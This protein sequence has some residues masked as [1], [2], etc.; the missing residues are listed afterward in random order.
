MHDAITAPLESA[1]G[2]SSFR[3]C[4]CMPLS[5]FPSTNGMSSCL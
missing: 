5:E 3:R 2:A 1:P 4:S